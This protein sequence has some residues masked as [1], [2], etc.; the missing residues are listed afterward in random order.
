MDKTKVLNYQHTFANCIAL[1]RVPKHLMSPYATKLHSCFHGAG[2]EFLPSG[3]LDSA[4]EEQHTFALCP[5]KHVS[6]NLKLDKLRKGLAIFEN[7]HFGYKEIETIYNAL[8][9]YPGGNNYISMGVYCSEEEKGRIRTL[10]NIDK[11][12]YYEDK[13]LPSFNHSQLDS[14]NSKGWP[15]G[16]NVLEYPGN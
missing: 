4:S 12:N 10:L 9:V 14:N 2:I 15:I 13:G 7:S 3:V 16:F 6:T 1:T 5:L 8:P 11:A